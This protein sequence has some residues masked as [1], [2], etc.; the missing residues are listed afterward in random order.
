[1]SQFLEWRGEKQSRG[2]RLAGMDRWQPLRN[3][4]QQ[5]V[6]N[7]AILFDKCHVVR[8]LGA[9]LDQVRKN[10]YA[11]LAGQERRFIKGQK[12]TLLCPGARTSPWR[13]AKR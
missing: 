3:A 13:D 5:H 4:P 2:I 1:M 9:A 7:A 11:R 10:E 6:P 12:Y 8:H